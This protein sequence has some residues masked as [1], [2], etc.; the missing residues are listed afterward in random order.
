V[1]FLGFFFSRLRLSLFPMADSMPQAC[2]S[3]LGL[4]DRPSSADWSGLVDLTT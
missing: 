2:N 3:K 1:V 4:S